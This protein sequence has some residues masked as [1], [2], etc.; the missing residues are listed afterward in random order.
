[1]TPCGLK[2]GA[3]VACDDDFSVSNSDCVIIEDE[4]TAFSDVV[5]SLWVEGVEIVSLL[6]GI[7]DSFKELGIMADV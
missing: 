3:L 4:N 2:G 1:M 7:A 6:G 5:R